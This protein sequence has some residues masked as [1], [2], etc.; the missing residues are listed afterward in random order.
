MREAYKSVALVA[1]LSLKV[2]FSRVEGKFVKPL[3]VAPINGVSDKLSSE[4]AITV[5]GSDVEEI[6]SAIIAEAV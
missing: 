4:T 6:H 2:V 5:F 3:T 1:L